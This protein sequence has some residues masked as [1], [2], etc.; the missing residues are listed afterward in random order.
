MSMGLSMHYNSKKRI[1]VSLEDQNNDRT[2]ID[3][4]GYSLT[5]ITFTKNFMSNVYFKFGIKNLFDYTDHNSSFPDFLSSY[6]PGR[7]F[8]ISINLDFSRDIK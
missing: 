7:R 1:D 4:P 8:F 2:E 6:M 3:L 5:N